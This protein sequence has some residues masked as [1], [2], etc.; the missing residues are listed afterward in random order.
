MEAC[1]GVEKYRSD[2]NHPQASTLVVHVGY[3]R[4]PPPASPP[5]VLS[6]SRATLVVHPHC[7]HV[8]RLHPHHLTCVALALVVRIASHPRRR[9]KAPP[10]L[11][12]APHA[13]RILHWRRL[14]SCACHPTR[15]C[16]CVPATSH[17]ATRSS[18]ATT[19]PACP[20]ARRH[21]HPLCPQLEQLP[22]R[23]LC[24]P[25]GVHALCELG[26]VRCVW[27]ARRAQLEVRS[28]TRECGS[29]VHGLHATSL[30][31]PATRKGVRTHSHTTKM[32]IQQIRTH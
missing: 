19:A 28:C 14:R 4:P 6:E 13:T 22:A 32:Y 18:R 23:H 27:P 3:H 26:L 8:C 25:H 12:A 20:A 31:A 10:P 9:R 29:C 30:P 21:A 7:L 24:A 11:S 2:A 5:P 17:P 15:P 16:V 1:G